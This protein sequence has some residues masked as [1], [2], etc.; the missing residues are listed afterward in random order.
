MRFGNKFISVLFRLFFGL[1]S[2]LWLF[3]MV[4][5]TV[6]G[7][8]S[9]T[10]ESW[11]A[12]VLA[13]AF[14]AFLLVMYLPLVETAPGELTAEGIYVRVFLLRRF[15]PWDSIRQ[16]GVLWRMGRGMHY[17]ELVLLKPGGSPRKYRD[18]LFVLRN[19]FRLIH[20]GDSPALREYVIRHY[21]PLDFDLS[22]G[23]PEQSVVLE[24]KER[25]RP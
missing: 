22:D 6:Y 13:A 20:L 8:G 9:G 25:F 17:N 14:C 19:R 5:I 12:A 21:G 11:T 3:A 23:R 24:Q 4:V 18:R 1:F 10:L 16:A 15:Y 2:C 7:L